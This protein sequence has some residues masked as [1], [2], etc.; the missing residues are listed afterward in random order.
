MLPS[1]SREEIDQ[2]NRFAVY[3]HYLISL[4]KHLEAKGHL[5]VERF[6]NL[7]RTNAFQKVQGRKDPDLA[8]TGRLLRNAWFTETQIW[9]AAQSSDYLSYANHWLGI[10]AYYSVYLGLRALFVSMKEEVGSTHSQNLKAIA[11]L[12]E[13]RPLLFPEPW[14]VLCEG[15]PESKPGFKNL[16]SGT[17]VNREISALSN[18]G[19]IPFYDYFGKFLSTTRRKAIERKCEEWKAQNK[20]KRVSSKF[21]KETIDKM[22]PTSLFDCLFRLRV[23][24]NYEDADSFLLAAE[25]DEAAKEFNHSF[26]AVVWHTLFLLE[27]LIARHISKSNYEALVQSFTK[28]ASPE[29]SDKL[30][31]GRWS[32]MKSMW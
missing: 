18:P 14:R 32:K 31:E 28:Y 8:K 30:V 11:K 6:S 9:M 27:M 24:S 2:Q 5:D 3:Y 20:R 17:K 29:F 25:N 10:Q 4:S 22:V 15:N 7:A 26:R 19:R 23:R 13:H 12:I 1:P 21:K 16:P